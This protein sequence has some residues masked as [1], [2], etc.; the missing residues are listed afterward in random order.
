LKG[1]HARS[2]VGFLL[3]LNE[4]VRGKRLNDECQV[5]PAAEALLKVSPNC[6]A[7]HTDLAAASTSGCVEY[8]YELAEVKRL[9][10]FCLRYRR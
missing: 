6:C 5:S 9:W 10:M 8:K 4:A 2:F 1:R 7:G 3:A